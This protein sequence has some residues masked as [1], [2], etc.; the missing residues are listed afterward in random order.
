MLVFASEC[1]FCTS[2]PTPNP[3]RH[4]TFSFSCFDRRHAA[5]GTEARGTFQHWICHGAYWCEDFRGHYEYARKQW[6]GLLQGMSIRSHTWRAE[7]TLLTSCWKSFFFFLVPQTQERLKGKVAL[8][9][10]G[11]CL[12]CIIQ[13]LLIMSKIRSMYLNYMFQFGQIILVQLTVLNVFIVFFCIFLHPQNCSQ[14]EVFSASTDLDAS[15]HSKLNTLLAFP[16]NRCSFVDGVIICGF[17]P[18]ARKKDAILPS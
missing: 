12:R 13:H 14:E 8:S 5:G 6:P 7:V 3:L 16:C 9:H 4:P 1:N 18:K 17:F 2:V 15:P 11:L 10:A